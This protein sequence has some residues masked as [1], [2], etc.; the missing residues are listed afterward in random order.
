[1]GH[2]KVAAL[3]IALLLSSGCTTVRW[4]V[5]KSM[6]REGIA[7]VSFPEAVWEEYGCSEQELPF[8]QIETNELI[9]LRVRPGGEFNHRITYALC[10]ARPTEVIEGV[11][12]TRILYR[13]KAIFNHVSE[14]HEFLPG[15]WRVDTFVEIP[16]DATPGIY[17]Y[18]LLFTSDVLRFDRHLTFL[19]PTP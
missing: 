14:Q 3:L 16:G 2:S 17:A 9:P 11:L 7:N 18:E 8:F 5:Q 15:R 13:G 6:R 19:V 12:E 1:M 4:A 10:P